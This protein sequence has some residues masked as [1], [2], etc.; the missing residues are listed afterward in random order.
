MVDLQDLPETTVE[1]AGKEK[2]KAED[3]RQAEEEDEEEKRQAAASQ[4][5]IWATRMFPG[6]LNHCV[7]VAEN[8]DAVDS[9]A[10]VV[11]NMIITHLNARYVSHVLPVHGHYA[12]TTLRGVRLR[13]TG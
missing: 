8:E 2:K 5:P 7:H 9:T 12:L 4:M 11:D 1:G 13:P 6:C 3:E 10:R